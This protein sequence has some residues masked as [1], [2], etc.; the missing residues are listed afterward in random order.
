[1]FEI[2][3]LVRWMLLVIIPLLV[4]LYQLARPMPVGLSYRSDE[5]NGTVEFLTDIT[6]EKGDE[7]V[8]EQEI[9]EEVFKL[10]DEAE[11]FIIL[12]MFLYNDD[13]DHDSHTFPNLSQSLTDKLIEKKLADDIEIVVITDPINNHYNSYQPEQFKQLEDVG[14]SCVVTD[15]SQIKDS[16]GLYSSFYRSYLQWYPSVNK[17]L[18]PNIFNKSKPNAN[19]ASYFSLLNFKA[20][21]RKVIVSEKNAII[22]SANPH[23]GSS[24]H[25]NVAVRVSGD[26]INKL[27]ETE[28]AVLEMSGYDTSLV[29]GLRAEIYEAKPDDLM[30]RV[31]TEGETFNELLNII[32]QAK[33]GDDIMIGT[34]YM[35][36]RTIIKELKEAAQRNVNIQ[37][38]LDQNID[39]FGK[40]KIGIPN[41]QVASELTNYDNIDIRWYETNG[42]QFHSKFLIHQADDVT[43]LN[44]GST[45]L[46]RRNLRDYNLETNITVRGVSGHPTLKGS[47]KYFDRLWNNIDGEYTV[48]YEVYSEDKLWKNI[49]YFIQETTGLSTF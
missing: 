44:V 35:A 30:V 5:H 2:N 19:L 17:K 27:L 32:H 42:E 37:L 14:I 45:N 7:R 1:M 38:I 4:M 28:M 22:S 6:Y 3:P 34:F 29:Q 9:F 24:Y 16:N 8:L 10:I 46:T 18:L 20:N 12:D 21:H 39:A 47:I 23:D 31:T 11:R 49:L 33:E 26:V 43:T 25:S 15:L 48:G 41:R 36:D 13:Y 40:K